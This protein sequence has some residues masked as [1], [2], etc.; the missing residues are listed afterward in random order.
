MTSTSPRHGE[1][2]V[3]E[4]PS[5]RTSQ[6]P[7]RHLWMQNTRV[8]RATEPDVPV[9][10]RGEGA[11][12]WDQRGRRYFDA[13][14][15]L[16]TTQVGYGR[17]ELADAAARQAKELSFF[18]LWTYAHPAAVELSERLAHL[19]PGDLNR[20]FF[21]SGGSESV[22]AA[23]KL[24]RQY[25]NVI[26]QPHRRKLI[27]RNVA[28]HGL[29]MGALGLTGIPAMRLPFE[30]LPFSSVKVPNTNFYH[31]EVYPDDIDRF[32]KWATDEIERAI[33][34]EGPETV[35]AVFLEPLQNAGGCFAPPP[36]YFERVRQICDKYGILLVSDEVIVA[37]GRLGEWFGSLRYE[38]EPDIITVAK[39]LTSGYSPLGAMI[40]SDR[41]AH[42]FEDRDTTFAHGV[43]FAGH[44]VSCAVALA[45]LEL[46]EREGIL[47][48][49]RANQEI[50]RAELTTLLELPIVGDI[51]GDGYL[52]AVELVKDKTTRVGFDTDETKRLLTDYMPSALFDA[53]I[54]CRADDRGD[55]VVTLAPPLTC[56]LAEFRIITRA[57]REVFSNAWKLL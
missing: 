47:A 42:E 20:V 56:G 8:R 12:V 38:Y 14:S 39:G 21:T 27:S 10:V 43:T 17:Q 4:S 23:L 48:N 54:L 11:Y 15:G 25:F 34:R 28:Y 41:I 22:E 52:Y 26:G 16:F 33:L 31:A 55:P 7:S 51:R 29:T 19:A 44:P 1:S 6:H 5:E 46:F 49:V 57:L 37:F 24:V 13:L 9:I 2:D 50:F 36:G 30:P 3:R 18:P 40:V 35:A 53:G 45:N 32:G